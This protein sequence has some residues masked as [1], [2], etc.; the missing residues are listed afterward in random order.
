MPDPSIVSAEVVLPCT[1]LAATLTFYCDRLGFRV[2]AI[3]PADDPRTA[4]VSGYGLRLRLQRGGSGAP[5]VLRLT[6]RLPLALGAGAHELTAPNGTRIELV[7]AEPPLLVP[8]APPTFVVS[9]ARDVN[10][11]V[12]GRAG[13]RYRDLIPGRQG[14]RFIASHIR[15]EDGGPV[16]DYVHFHRVRV[17]VIYCHRGWVRVVYEGQGPPFVMQ[18]GD[19][20][21]QP[22]QIRHRV[23][24]CS[25]GLEVI[26][27]SCPAEHATLADHALS[28][29]TETLPSETRQPTRVFSGQSFVHH[30]AAAATWHPALEGFEARDLG[31]AEGTDGLASA[32]VLRGNGG[33]PPARTHDGELLFYCVLQGTL[34]LGVDGH[35]PHDLATGDACT[36]PAAVGFTLAACSDDLELLEVSLPPPA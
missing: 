32:R 35:D 7:D 34:T 17:Q 3:H 18:A 19:C 1:D 14:G 22:P 26:E 5:G 10:A 6:C 13:M 27:V 28:L 11:W 33:T 23:L 25:P 36:L 31:I 15:I 30:R 20:V 8:D 24:E 16:P 9:R 21:L 12:E 2:E 29:P 4:V